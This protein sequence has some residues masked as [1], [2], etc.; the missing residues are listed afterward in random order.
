V[1]SRCHD[2]RRQACERSLGAP[3]SRGLKPLAAEKAHQKAVTFAGGTAKNAKSA[4][5]LS[6]PPPLMRRP[7]AKERSQPT[8][9]GKG[10]LEAIRKLTAAWIRKNGAEMAEDLTDDITEIGPAF[11]SP[12]VGK[13]DFLSR[14]RA[15]LRGPLRIEHYKILRPRLIRLTARLVLVHFSYQMIARNGANSDRSRGQESMLVERV[16]RHWRVKFIHWHRTSWSLSKIS[17]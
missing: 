10:A 7:A 17:L 3:A 14:Y 2:S 4:K 8:T 13:K 12:L 1:A 9:Q 6:D 15:Y 16:G 5:K 11:T